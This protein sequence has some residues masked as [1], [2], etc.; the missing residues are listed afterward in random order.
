MI[1]PW[2]KRLLYLITYPYEQWRHRVFMRGWNAGYSDCEGKQRVVVLQT[3]PK[4]Q[5]P[6]DEQALLKFEEEWPRSD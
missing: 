3:D 6:L 4:Y 1:Y 2:Y 5:R